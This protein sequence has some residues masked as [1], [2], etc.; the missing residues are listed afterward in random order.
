MATKKELIAQ[1]IVKILVSHL[2]SFPEDGNNN[3]NA[4]FH[5]TFLNAFSDKLN[6]RVRDIPLY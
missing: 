2:S 1:T 4:P 3:R 6:G 5:V